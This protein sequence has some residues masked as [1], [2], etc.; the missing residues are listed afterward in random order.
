M[1]KKDPEVTKRYGWWDAIAF[2]NHETY[3]FIAHENSI[4]RQSEQCNAPSTRLRE[5]V[6]EQRTGGHTILERCDG[7]VPFL[8]DFDASKGEHVG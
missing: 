4:H 1:L 8:I 7:E 2:S 3:N 5:G 6:M